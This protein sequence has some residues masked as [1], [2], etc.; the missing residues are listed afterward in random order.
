MQR[1]GR[2]VRWRRRQ[3]FRTRRSEG[4]GR[5]SACS[6][7]G[8]RPSSFPVTLCSST[9]SGTSSVFLYRRLI[10]RWGLSVD[11]K[12]QRQALDREQPVL[13]MMPGI[14]ER[15]THSYVRH[16]TNVA[17]RGSRHRLRIRARQ[18]LQA[19]SGCRGAASTFRALKEVFGEHGLPHTLNGFRPAH[20]TPSKASDLPDRSCAT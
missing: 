3:V 7:I 8:R 14:P 10:G 13:P 9:K 5:L 20:L 19:S 11:E 6:L 18:M 15:R 1:T 4:F 17:V 12:S 2:S 16:G